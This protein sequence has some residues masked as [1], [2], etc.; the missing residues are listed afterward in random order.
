MGFIIEHKLSSKQKAKKCEECL[1][2]LQAEGK[3]PDLNALRNTLI[4]A[5]SLTHSLTND[6]HEQEQNAQAASKLATHIEELIQSIKSWA[7]SKNN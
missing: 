2:F 7:Q 1:E 4:E 6:L 5:R 3:L